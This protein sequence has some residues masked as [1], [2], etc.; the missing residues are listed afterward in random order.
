M[1]KVSYGRPV[2]L[3][4]ALL[5]AGLLL[6]L[7]FV[8]WQP[9]VAG[10][11]LLY[12]DIAQNWLHAHVYG[13]STDAAP[14]PTL[15]RLPGYPAVLAL[16]ALATDR[17]V[18]ADPGT[19]QSFFPVLYLQIAVDLFTCC[20]LASLA[21]RLFGA[22][23]GQVALALGCLCPFLANYTAVPLTETFALFTM[24]LA[25]WTAQRWRDRQRWPMLV[26][27]AAALSGSILLRPDQ[28]LLA[29]AVWPL[30]RLPGSQSKRS[31]LLPVIVCVV[32]VALPFVPWTVR[33]ARTF[34][35]FQPLAPRLANDPG[36]AVPRGFQRWYRTFAVDFASTEDAYW[37]YPEEPVVV[38]DLPARAFDSSEQRVRT[39]DLLHQAAAY[40]H[41]DARVDAGFAE[42]AA[43]RIRARPV[44]YYLMLPAARLTNML[45]HPR[46]EMLPVAERWWQ[47]QEHPRQSAFAVFYGLLGVAYLVLALRGLPRALRSAPVVAVSLCGFVLLRCALLLTLDNAEQ[48]YT[49]EFFPVWILL[50]AACFAAGRR[51]AQ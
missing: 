15:I 30:L 49:L 10:D 21:H 12:Q 24:A 29:L 36:E 45:F 16:L 32:L 43:E 31:R 39:V 26:T 2:V 11:S 46:V 37:K 23:A 18:Q 6:R 38:S 47:F 8:R 34:G 13:L 33:N 50:G 28:A 14:R 19:L 35:V 27:V 1:R 44:R 41:L 48:R 17:F 7:Y 51:E 25:Y 9:F 42:L 3:A 5:C 40:S 22:R 20:L 4:A